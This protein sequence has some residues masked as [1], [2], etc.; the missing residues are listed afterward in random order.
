ML[1]VAPAGFNQLGQL[2][3]PLTQQN[4]DI[5][6]RLADRMLYAHQLIVEHDRVEQHN[7]QHYQHNDR[8]QF[9]SLLSCST[10][11]I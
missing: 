7:A 11:L 10:H 4:I 8:C 2:I 1:H 6:P 3:M 5:G 9:H